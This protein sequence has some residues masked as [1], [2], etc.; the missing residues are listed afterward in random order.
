MTRKS[1]FTQQSSS[2]GG[3]EGFW[4]SFSGKLSV[5]Y[6]YT[7]LPQRSR[8][9]S[10]TLFVSEMAHIFYGNLFPVDFGLVSGLFSPLDDRSEPLPDGWSKIVKIFAFKWPTE[11]ASL[12]NFSLSLWM[13]WKRQPQNPLSERQMWKWIEQVSNNLSNKR[14]VFT[15]RKYIFSLWWTLWKTFIFIEIISFNVA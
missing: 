14:N 11:V 9:I 8:S 1:S 6:F 2:P 3:G 4:F 5:R 15:M 7:S 13:K 10:Q 12:H